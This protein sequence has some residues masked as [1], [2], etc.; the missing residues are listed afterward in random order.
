MRPG[1]DYGSGGGVGGGEED[2]DD[3]ETEGGETGEEEEYDDDA[4][5]DAI[6]RQETGGSAA[7]SAAEVANALA[8]DRAR[9]DRMRAAAAALVG[10]PLNA[11]ELR[12]VS[13]HRSQLDELSSLAVQERRLLQSST[14]AK[15]LTRGDVARYVGALQ[16]ALQRKL[17]LVSDL[18]R[19]AE[20][21]TAVYGREVGLADPLGDHAAAA[22]PRGVGRTL[23]PL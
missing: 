14:D 19:S 3:A 7:A 16:D 22:S 2:E 9:Q 21:Y 1:F 10:I 13:A 17:L 12:L 5:E 8:R 15:T 18:L 4:E 6:T 20:E 11:A 23:S